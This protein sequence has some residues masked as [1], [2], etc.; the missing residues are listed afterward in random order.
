MLGTK[1][2]LL[3]VDDVE[4]NR[5]ILGALFEEQY[6]IFEAENGQQALDMLG[7]H[8]SAISA[9]L[10]DIV[11]PVMDGLTVLQEMKK[12]HWN[13]MVPVLL[14]TAENS[15]DTFLQGYTLG[16]SDIINKPFRPGI[17]RRRV[18][19]HHSRLRTAPKSAL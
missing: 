13:D 1:K 2:A 5:T 4:I 8:K 12:R 9:M 3:I 18:Y 10:L 11:M 19:P 16:V 6:T 14:I 7:K 15:E 17:V